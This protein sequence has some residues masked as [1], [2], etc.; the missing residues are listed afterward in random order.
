MN[1]S[2]QVLLDALPQY[3]V[4]QAPYGLSVTV[5]LLCCDSRKAGNGSLFFCVVGTTAD[6]H[7]FAAR[8]YEQGARVFV[9]QRPVELPSDA[10]LI[11]VPDTRKAMALMAAAFY[12]YPA[13]R[14]RVIGI[15]GTKGKTTTALLIQSVLNNAG[16]HT[17]YVG[18]NGISYREEHIPTVNSTPESLIIHEHLRKMLDADVTTVVMEISS[19]ALWMDR[20]YGVDVDIAIF[21][22][23]SLDHV[24]GVEHPDFEHYKACKRLLF[25][26]HH[27][28]VIVYNADDPAW[29]YMTD[30]CD[31][32]RI[33]ISTAQHPEASWWARRIRPHRQGDRIGTAFACSRDGK[34]FRGPQFLPLPGGFNVQNALCVLAVVCDVFGV[35]PS[36]AFHALAEASVAGRF[37]T[38]THP[39]CPG[40]TFVIDY[41]HN[42]VSLASI[43]DA[44]RAYKP[45][46]LICLF[47][48][49]GERT[50]GRRTDLA[51]AAAHRADLCILTSDN[52]GREDPMKILG[53]I[54]AAFPEGSCPR[55]IIE[56]RQEAIAYAVKIAREGDII[57]LAGKGH[58]NYQLEGTVRIAYSEH[59][60]LRRALTR[61]ES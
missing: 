34:V 44:L 59:S 57:L 45:R 41:A 11:L 61:Q 40:V 49:V 7:G 26:Q 19:Q 51:L 47:G 50:V 15:T 32:Q 60:A 9:G 21:T 39:A 3:D 2:L 31:G 6:G 55:V 36:V 12:G 37:E 42:G 10:T 23:L 14:M 1:H 38:V 8:A 30:G 54:D 48:S 20:L 52:P 27:P 28:R 17:G 35:R 16:I 25:T 18:T 43:L 4:H 29:V 22:N 56:N 53:E 13:R 5:D 46:K 33:G 24:G 58:E